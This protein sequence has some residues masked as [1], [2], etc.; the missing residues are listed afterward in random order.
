MT[1]MQIGDI[2]ALIAT[3][4]VF[5]Y[6]LGDFFPQRLANIVTIPYR[7]AVYIFAGLTA[8]F[9][10][11]VTFD[12]AIVPYLNDLQA[13]GGP[14]VFVLRLLPLI[15]VIGLLLPNFPPALGFFNLFKRLALAFLIGAGAAITVVGVVSGTLIPL[16]VETGQSLGDGTDRVTLA[17]GVLTLI[18][19]ISTLLYFQ[20]GARRTP[21]GQ[22]R[23]NIVVRV[24]RGVGGIFLA[25]AFGV[26]YARAIAS[27]LTVF[28]ERI[29]FL[30]AQLFGG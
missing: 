11:I 21:T 25:I 28:T 22:I 9:V 20:Y 10:A 17:T 18:G 3:L 26:L 24:L 8:G 23:Q 5:T 27:T 2:V 1:L 29:Q 12:S 30:L 13:P 15:F 6:L 19:V 14:V 16:A 4:F 7:L